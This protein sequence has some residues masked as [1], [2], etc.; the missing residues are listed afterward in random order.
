MKMLY[1]GSKCSEETV[2]QKSLSVAR[3]C[4]SD[5]LSSGVLL[6]CVLQLASVFI[7]DLS[8]VIWYI[9]I[10]FTSTNQAKKN[11]KYGGKQN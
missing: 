3:C 1:S 10:Q 6:K 2:P 4:T 7:N 8:D 11:G 9:L 5:H